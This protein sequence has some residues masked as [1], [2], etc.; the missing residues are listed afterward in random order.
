MVHRITGWDKDMRRADLTQEKPQVRQD[1]P[2]V[3]SSLAAIAKDP[4]NPQELLAYQPVDVLLATWQS[5]LLVGV[6]LA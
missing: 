5:L 2:A 4:K 6:T 1:N 3:R